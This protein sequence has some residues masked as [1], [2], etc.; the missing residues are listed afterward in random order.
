MDVGDN[1]SGNGVWNSSAF[2]DDLTPTPQ[3]NN[4]EFNPSLRG[5][6]VS[7]GTHWNG[8]RGA[9]SAPSSP[10]L[11]RTQIDSEVV[12]PGQPAVDDIAVRTWPVKQK[13]P[14]SVSLTDQPLNWSAS[15]QGHRRTN[16]EICRDGINENRMPSHSWPYSPSQTQPPAPQHSYPPGLMPGTRDSWRKN[17]SSSSVTQTLTSSGFDLGQTLQRLGLEKYL[18]VFQVSYQ[19]R[20]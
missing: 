9:F 14:R 11:Q 3:V 19:H 4:I 1:T 15:N 5:Q 10:S 12:P 7:T 13:S 16:S 18:H 20:R 8:N 2:A 17:T 6:G